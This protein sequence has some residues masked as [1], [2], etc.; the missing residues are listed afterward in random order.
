MG[1]GRGSVA[2]LLEATD[3]NGVVVATQ[4]GT[5]QVLRCATLTV[6]PTATPTSSPTVT[7]TATATTLPS[8]TATTTRTATATVTATRSP[9]LTPT[10]TATR[11]PTR[12]A[13]T[14]PTYTPTATPTPDRGGPQIGNVLAQP[15]PVDYNSLCPHIFTVQANVSDPSGVKSVVLTYRYHSTDATLKVGPWRTAA[16]AEIEPGLFRARIDISQPSEAPADMVSKQGGDPFYTRGTLDYYL[17][18]TDTRGNRA[19]NKAAAV[20]LTYNSCVIPLQ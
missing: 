17:S 4:G 5:L 19:N 1:S 14:A 8:A 6:S 7:V 16:L 15:Q 20:P 13:T 18:A 3:P 10:P 12:T 2:Y 9:T 11:T